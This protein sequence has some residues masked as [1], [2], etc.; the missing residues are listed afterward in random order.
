MKT[1][2]FPLYG[3]EITAKG[4]RLIKYAIYWAGSQLCQ[5]KLYNAMQVCFSAASTHLPCLSLHLSPNPP[6]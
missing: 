2:N 4:K 6:R 3:K 5:S 1:E